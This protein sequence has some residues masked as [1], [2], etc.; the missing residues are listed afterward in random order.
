MHS[1]ASRYTRIKTFGTRGAK[2]KVSTVPKMGDVPVPA[3]EIFWKNKRSTLKSEY[4]IL[5]QQY[6]DVDAHL[7]QLF[8]V[9]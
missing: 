8:K 3:Y 2:W 5:V 4:Q 1:A 9:L 6:R 7:K